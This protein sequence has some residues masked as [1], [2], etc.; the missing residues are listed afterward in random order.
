MIRALIYHHRYWEIF[1]TKIF[2]ENRNFKDFTENI[3]R[4]THVNKKK[5]VTW[6]YFCEINFLDEAC[7]KFA[8][9]FCHN[10]F[11]VY[12]IHYSNVS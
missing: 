2:C 1:A 5:G 9:I 4:M 8:K 12:G 11:P 3:L 6:Q 7:T 10:N